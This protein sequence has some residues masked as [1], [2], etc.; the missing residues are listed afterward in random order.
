M[1]FWPWHACVFCKAA[2]A[3][4]LIAVQ[5]H[6]GFY[7]MSTFHLLAKGR[8]AIYK[9]FEV[10]AFLGFFTWCAPSCWCVRK[11]SRRVVT[12]H[13]ACY[14]LVAEH[15]V[16]PNPPSISSFRK[17]VMEHDRIR[18][19]YFYGCH[20][21]IHSCMCTGTLLCAFACQ[22]GRSA[23]CSSPSPMLALESS[24]CRQASLLLQWHVCYVCSIQTMHCN[25]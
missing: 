8:P 19:N 10:A 7:A 12:R 11:N 6:A 1:G 4:R 15:I 14:G 20:C 3:N 5:C 16:L 17:R 21:D 23:Y 18:A 2:L 9:P 24:T 13:L 22:H 25:T